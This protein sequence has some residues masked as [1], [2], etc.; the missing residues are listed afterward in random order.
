M[1]MHDRMVCL[2]RRDVKRV[3][4]N[5]HFGSE[6]DI[7]AVSSEAPALLRALDQLLHFPETRSPKGP[8]SAA[9]VP[10][11][12][13]GKNKKHLGFRLSACSNWW[14]VKDSN[15]GPID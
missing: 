9:Y 13:A 14:A 8:H 11:S 5:D 3:P 6:A 10:F 1:E 12:R 15:L 4:P 7:S 2:M